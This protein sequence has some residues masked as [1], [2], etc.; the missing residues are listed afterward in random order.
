MFRYALSFVREGSDSQA[1]AAFDDFIAKYQ[2]SELIQG[3]QFW[4]GKCFIRR[5]MPRQAKKEFYGIAQKTPLDYYGFKA[6]TILLELGDSS[7]Q[8]IRPGNNSAGIS[9]ATWLDSTA[10]RRGRQ[11]EPAD[12]VFLNTGILLAAIGMNE[13]ADFLLEPLAACYDNNIPLLL[14]LAQ[15][16][17][18]SDDITR[19]FSIARRFSW[20]IPQSERLTMPIEMFN[21]LYPRGFSKMYN[22]YANESGID[23]CLAYAITRQESLFNPAIVS[24]VGAIGLMQIMPYTGKEIADDFGE[25]F[26][27]DSLYSASYNIRSGCYY[28]SKMLKEFNG[29]MICAIASYNGGPHN[30]KTWVT[31]AAGKETDLFVED[32]AFSET[33][34]YVKKVLGNYWVYKRLIQEN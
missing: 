21:L 2:N 23:P 32:I 17:A 16:Y 31:R 8:E 3:A 25:P 5:G 11:L 10:G 28:I 7:C 19:A 12:S 18:G 1:I 26:N 4:K 20:R 30:V 9:I 24:P 33:R 13:H 29:D 14:M 22:K 27:V 34:N 15:S 6:R